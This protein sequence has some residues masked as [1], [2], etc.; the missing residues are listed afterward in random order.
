MERI[1]RKDGCPAGSDL[2]CGKSVRLRMGVPKI[3][4]RLLCGSQ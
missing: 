2:C 1:I 3:G 4:R